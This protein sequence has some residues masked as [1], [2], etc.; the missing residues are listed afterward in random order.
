MTL[1]P[2][3]LGRF[4]VDPE[5]GLVHGWAASAG[6][7]DATRELAIVLGQT[8]IATLEASLPPP[9]DAPPDAHGFRWIAPRLLFS[10]KSP[11]PI[12]VVDLATGEGLDGPL[13]I[14]RSFGPRCAIS[15]TCAAEPPSWPG[16]LAGKLTSRF[17]EIADGILADVDPA[18][19]APR[20]ALDD[21]PPSA[22]GAAW[23]VRLGAE[24][25]VGWTLHQ[26]LPRGAAMSSG[27]QRF[28]LWMK[29]TRAVC[30]RTQCHVEIGLGTWT[31]ER[32][33]PLRRLR[34]SR[35]LRPFSSSEVVLALDAGER[36]AAVDGELYLTVT[37]QP[38]F[39]VVICPLVPA[40]APAGHPGFEDNRLVGSFAELRRL[41]LIS[42]D[43]PG[44]QAPMAPG[45]P[46]VT[47]A[48]SKTLPLTD[49][50]VP[51]HNGGDVVMRCLRSLQRATDAPFRVWIID[52]GS[53]GYTALMLDEFAAG[54]G[55]FRLHRRAI[56]RGY[57]KSINE[58]IRLTDAPWVV[59]L[60][61]DTV[62]S[63]G[64]LGRLHRAAATTPAVG[65]V[66]PL[67]N[68]A[69]W[70][71][72]PRAKNPDHSWAQ[73]AFIGPETVD[74]VQRKL[75]A[76]SEAAHPSVPALNGFCTLIARAVFEACGDYDEEAFPL[77]YG[78]ETDLCL[79][80]SLAGFKLVLADDCFVYHEKSVSFGSVDRRRLTRAGRFELRNKHPGVNVAALELAM[81]ANPVLLR[82]RAKLL[83][84]E[85][86][87]RA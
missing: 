50:I 42:G 36:A 37:T 48:R 30:D 80:A 38:S 9:H 39:G 40:E 4:A 53:R 61:S 8:V 62:V 45:P 87:L 1:R 86:E 52:D 70:Q 19:Q 82:L 46:C 47:E 68:A 77:G 72:V 54:D 6:S 66:G 26:R 25:Q 20:F 49:I 34:Q 71:S 16:G 73:N 18:A 28:K 33:E 75:A 79:R 17:N 10:R 29:L 59:T 35:V 60:N 85:A 64:W 63:Q 12:S 22:Q 81:Q 78:E 43:G 51:V 76:V 11:G 83:D 69:T 65:M 84:L 3:R 67:S 14:E 58:A 7:T 31:G 15:E 23:A 24:N 44:R 2:G 56:N 32:F 21:P 74:H 5:R 27:D 55:R 41:A 13:R 57:T